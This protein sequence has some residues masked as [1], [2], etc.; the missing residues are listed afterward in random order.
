MRKAEAKYLEHLLE[1]PVHGAEDHGDS[2]AAVPHTIPASVDDAT[3]LK[4]WE[5]EQGHTSTRWTVATFF[6]SVSFAILGFSFQ[7]QLTY[8]PSLIARVSGLFIYWF[9]YLLFTR[10]NLYT[11]LLRTYMYELELQKRTSLDIQTRT[12]QKLRAGLRWHLSA[13]RLLF[14]FGLLYTSGVA[15]LWWFKL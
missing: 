5:I 2:A 13:T 1:V 11:E 9:A 10:F 8:P 7:A 14:Y 4:I 6:L 3:Y 15:L 12:R